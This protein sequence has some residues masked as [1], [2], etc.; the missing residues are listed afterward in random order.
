MGLQI[1][2][3]VS[4]AVGSY[5]SAK[6]QRNAI[7]AQAQADQITAQ[8]TAL[9]THGQ[10]DLDAVSAQANY[11]TS[12]VG[13]EFDQLNIAHQ[14]SDMRAQADISAVHAEGQVADLNARADMDENSAKLLEL[15]AQ[16][17]L[18]RG[19]QSEQAARMKYAQQ[20]SA[21][22][23]SLGAHNIDMAQG[24]GLAVRAGYD[25]MSE[26]T[27]I[28]IKQEALMQA[29]GQRVQEQNSLIQAASARDEAGA[30]AAAS[31]MATSLAHINANYMEATGNASLQAAKA[32]AA[33]NLLNADA[34]VK[35]KNT[36]ADVIEKNSSAAA[37]LK[38]S[39]ADAINPG[40]SA[41]SSLLGSGARVA[42]AWYKYKHV[43][44]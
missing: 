17:S 5:Y 24:A 10:A 16:S 29:F 42:D 41:F 40:M 1:G 27:A 30:T 28:Q 15:Q 4:G 38:G 13:A 35:Y 43:G 7:Q 26:N 20:K 31:N 34:A 23:A 11:N 36:M 6:E 9:A 3:A 21:A 14:A 22:T 44:G 12:I 33:A 25:L 32:L 8:S 18:L 39:M 2:G 37:L 19:E